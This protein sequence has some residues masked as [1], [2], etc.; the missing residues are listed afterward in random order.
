M[1]IITIKCD[2]CDWKYKPPQ[3]TLAELK[4][5]HNK[6]CPKCLDCIIITDKDIAFFRFISFLAISSK[7]LNFIT[8]G[9]AKL[10]YMHV[11]S[12]I[13]KGRE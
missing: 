5:W 7:I 10:Y 8:F 3:S 2:K 1:E 9:R 13:L 12:K 4:I 6:P 11:D